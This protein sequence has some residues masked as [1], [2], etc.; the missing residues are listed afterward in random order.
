[1]FAGMG[2]IMWLVVDRLWRR[3]EQFSFSDFYFFILDF[4]AA[5]PHRSTS[6]LRR[7]N[8]LYILGLQYTNNK[9]QRGRINDNEPTPKSF[10]L[11][12]RSL[13]HDGGRAAEACDGHHNSTQ[14]DGDV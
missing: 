9:S 4:V 7:I 1:M 2:A 11:R 6:L 8:Q 13:A 3:W 14:P 12:S 5:N 10:F